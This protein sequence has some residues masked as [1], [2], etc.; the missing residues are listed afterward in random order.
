MACKTISL[1]QD[2]YELLLKEKRADRESFSQ[3]V[4]R[5]TTDRPALTAGELDRALEPFV[6]KGAGKKRRRNAAA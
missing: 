3:V 5:L 2:A 1:E 6:G 4:R